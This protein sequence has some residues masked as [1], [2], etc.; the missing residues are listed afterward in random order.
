[1][2]TFTDSQ[3]QALAK[4]K[5]ISGKDYTALMLAAQKAVEEAVP[6]PQQADILAGIKEALLA[7]AAK[8]EPAKDS[9]PCPAPQVTVNL[10]TRGTWTATVTERDKNGFIKRVSFAEVGA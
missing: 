9:L 2:K 10:P 7:I 3:I 8:I 5:R 1:M 4:D 6:A